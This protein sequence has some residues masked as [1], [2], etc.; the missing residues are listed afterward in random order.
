MK[1]LKLD[2]LR[3]ED[4]SFNIH[5]PSSRAGTFNVFG[6]AGISR[7][8]SE[9]PCN[10]PDTAGPAYDYEQPLREARTVVGIKH[11]LVLSPS[12]FVRSTVVGFHK[13]EAERIYARR[14]LPTDSLNLADEEFTIEQGIRGQ[15]TLHL[16]LSSRYVIQVGMG[17]SLLRYQY[18]FREQDPFPVGAWLSTLQEK[19]LAL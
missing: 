15:S 14:I 18:R 17:G 12:L 5:L 13:H 9:D 3:Y 1:L 4:L 10:C 16:K 7:D 2:D 6:V 11:Q 19:D 8:R